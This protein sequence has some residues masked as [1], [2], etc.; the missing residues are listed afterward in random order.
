MSKILDMHDN[1]GIEKT[2][3]KT[4]HFVRMLYGEWIR[5]NDFTKKEF[6]ELM[7]KIQ[8]DSARFSSFVELYE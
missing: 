6:K 8:K 1:I 3:K 2:D 5:D 4:F 7:E